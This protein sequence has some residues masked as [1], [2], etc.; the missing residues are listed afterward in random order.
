MFTSRK[1]QRQ[2]GASMA[3]GYFFGIIAIIAVIATRPTFGEK[4]LYSALIIGVVVLLF[5]IRSKRKNKNK[6]IS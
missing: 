6:P 4:L 5:Y 2:S 3:I 1:P